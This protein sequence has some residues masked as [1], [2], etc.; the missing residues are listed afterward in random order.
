MPWTTSDVI[1]EI[2]EVEKALD[3]E[4]PDVEW[5]KKQLDWIRSV[6]EGHASPPS[7]I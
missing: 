4:E 1:E 6:I 7:E 3:G 2:E 5:A